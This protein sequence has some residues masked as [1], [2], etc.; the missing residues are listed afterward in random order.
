MER[1]L[2]G[3]VVADEDR[4][5][6]FRHM[7]QR[8]TRNAALVKPL[9]R[10]NIENEF[11]PLLHNDARSYVWRAY[12]AYI[13]AQA[14]TVGNAKRT[15]METE[16]ETLILEL[17]TGIAFREHGE[18]STYIPE[19]LG[20]A[21]GRRERAAYSAE[22][23]FEAVIAGVPQMRQRDALAEVRDGTPG[24]DDDRMSRRDR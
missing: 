1:I 19:R 21:R 14:R 3:R 15:E 22:P 6:A 17:R 4:Q 9:R 23:P 7:L 11:M 12:C 13:F 10:P 5:H 24:N 2:V 20:R 18:R 8:K 16:R